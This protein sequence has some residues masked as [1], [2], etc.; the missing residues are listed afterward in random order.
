MFPGYSNLEGA[1]ERGWALDSTAS[2]QYFLEEEGKPIFIIP[3]PDIQN[4]KETYCYTN[5]CLW[6][7]SIETPLP[8][9]WPVLD[10]TNCLP[11]LSSFS[12][13]F[14]AQLSLLYLKCIC[15]LTSLSAKTTWPS[16]T[17]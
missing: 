16:L 5:E 13:R 15:H 17:P 6:W 9:I 12:L 7:S 10:F 2:R 8:R 11:M 4:F 1:E 3:S 14:I